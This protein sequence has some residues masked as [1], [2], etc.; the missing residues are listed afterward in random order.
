MSRDYAGSWGQ[1]Y[2]PD[3]RKDPDDTI[4]HT[5]NWVS[6]LKNATI[7]TSTWSLGTGDLLLEANAGRLLL[8]GVSSE[9]LQEESSSNTANTATIMLSGGTLGQHN[10]TNKISTSDSQ[11]LSKTVTVKVQDM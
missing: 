3:I 10:A 2:D 6:R 4:S 11:V 9:G 5:V 1:D 8:E 7:S